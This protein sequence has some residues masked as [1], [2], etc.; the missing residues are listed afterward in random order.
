MRR[1]WRVEGVNDRELG[2]KEECEVGEGGER[3]NPLAVLL[4]VCHRA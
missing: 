1:G 2:G 4:N 3:R